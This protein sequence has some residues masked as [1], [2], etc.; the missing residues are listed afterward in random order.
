MMALGTFCGC[1]LR[2]G[3]RAFHNYMRDTCRCDALYRQIGEALA[4]PLVA[5]PMLTILGERNDPFPF[6]HR[7]KELFPGAD[8]LLV[9]KG[10]HFPMCD[11]PGFVVEAIRSWHADRVNTQ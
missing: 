10:N 8:Q 11:A 1:Y 7:S 6:Q 9:A 4:G 2:V 3:R 5:V